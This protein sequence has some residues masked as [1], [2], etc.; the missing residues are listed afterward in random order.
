MKR[1]LLLLMRAATLMM[2]ISSKGALSYP[3]FQRLLLRSVR[4]SNDHHHNSLRYLAS[5]TPNGRNDKKLSAFKLDSLD[6]VE[7]KSLPP[8][9]NNGKSHD[10]A[11]DT[12]SSTISSTGSVKDNTVA[13]WSR[14]FVQVL[15][16]GAGGIASTAG[17]LSS[18]A[19]SIITDRAQFRRA[20][21]TVEALKLFLKKSGIDLEL[22]Q[23]LNVHLLRNV[24]VLG[25]IQKVL[26][27]RSDRRELSKTK[28]NI[29]IPS[30]EEALRYM[31]YATAAYGSN[32]IAAAE[33]GARGIFDKRFNAPVTKTRISEH[34]GIPEDDIVLADVEYSGDVNNLR[35]Y[36]AVDHANQ[37]IVLAI[38]GT[39]TLSEIIVDVAAFT[40]EFFTLDMLYFAHSFGKL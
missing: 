3:T 12:S 1:T 28:Q 8:T 6:A 25:R 33:M 29:V 10:T 26:A 35:H 4:R 16:R 19:T 36:V 34:I 5:N 39:F 11:T 31:R 13:P 20:K 24:I 22:S 2:M 14:Y 40:R 38:R 30:R 32:M 18:A 37:K 21:P 7:E 27:E 15:R 23:S 9:K 17:F